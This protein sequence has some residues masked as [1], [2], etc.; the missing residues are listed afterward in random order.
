MSGIQ[1]ILVLVLLV[2]A[3]FFLPRIFSRAQGTGGTAAGKKITGRKLSGRWR[4]A[5]LASVIWPLGVALFFNPLYGSPMPF[6]YLG[7]IPV[8]VAWG[9]A[10]VAAGYRRESQ[11]K[12]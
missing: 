8:L 9:I 1:E 6:L 7:L 12:P 3:I 4:L 11:R 2:L 10:W 5:L